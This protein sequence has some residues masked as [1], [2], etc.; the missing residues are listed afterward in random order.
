MQT[1]E[2]SITILRGSPFHKKLNLYS[3]RIG[4]PMVMLLKV[5]FGTIFNDP[6]Q[7]RILEEPPPLPEDIEEK[8]RIGNFAS[9]RYLFQSAEAT[10]EKTIVTTDIK[11]INHFEGNGRYRL[12][13]VEEFMTK[14]KI[15]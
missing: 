12:W 4:D 10:E 5:F 7:C 15:T 8:L 13:D 2:H 11:L 6:T 3:S 9:D 1:S 14:F